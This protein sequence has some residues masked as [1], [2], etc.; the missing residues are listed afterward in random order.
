MFKEGNNNWGEP[1]S[2]NVSGE[3]KSSQETGAAGVPIF[4]ID[5]GSRKIRAV[6]GYVDGNEKVEIVGIAEADSAGITKGIITDPD[7]AAAA[8]RVAVDDLS[9]FFSNEIKNVF[10]S[11]PGQHLRRFTFSS[12]FV[13]KDA[14]QPVTREEAARFIQQAFQQV[15]LS[16]GERVVHLFPQEFFIDDRGGIKNPEGLMVKEIE[17]EFQVMTGQ[18]TLVQSVINC[19]GKAGLEALGFIP[20]YIASAEAV[21]SDEEKKEGVALLDIGSSA[22]QV[23]IF[24][25]GQLRYSAVI[26]FGSGSVTEDIKDGFFIIRK[27]AELLKMKSGSALADEVKGNEIATIRLKGEPKEVSLK[28]LAHIIQARTEEIL[29]MVMLEIKNSGLE[30]ELK[31][32]I[33]LTGGGAQLK[34]I[35]RLVSRHSGM[36]S[37]I[38]YPVERLAG[39]IDMET[40]NPVNA[41]CV[42]LVVKGYESLKFRI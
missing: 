18:T 31:R 26:P 30:K 3:I 5:L 36:Q 21:L 32:G 34:N 13:R 33:V 41:V 7:A 25:E 2:E 37:R 38:G 8:I 28:N 10:V 42:G 20:A 23:V 4:G 9:L 22:T 11:I 16:A 15:E 12:S 24:Q 17:A 35:A 40:R 14:E 29:D 27:E 19:L 6:A 1:F 39:G